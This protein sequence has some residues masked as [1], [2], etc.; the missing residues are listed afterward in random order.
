[1]NKPE[2]I[3]NCECAERVR[4]LLE[5]R[6]ELIGAIQWMSGSADFAPGGIAHKGWLKIRHLAYD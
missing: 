3:N 6:S 2:L 4:E 1:M 5:E